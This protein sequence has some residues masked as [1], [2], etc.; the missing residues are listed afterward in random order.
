MLPMCQ[1][2][3]CC[4][5]T[6]PPVAVCHQCATN[7]CLVLSHHHAMGQ[8]CYQCDHNLICAIAPHPMLRYA[9]SN[10]ALSIGYQT[11]IIC[12][13]CYDPA[14]ALT[15]LRPPPFISNALPMNLL[16]IHATDMLPH[17]TPYLPI[18]NYPCHKVPPMRSQLASQY[19]VIVLGPPP[20]AINTLWAPCRM[21]SMHYPY[22]FSM[23]SP[24][25][26]RT[27]HPTICT[28]RYGP[29]VLCY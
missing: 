8:I 14:T 12:D 9:P 7:A 27:L 11:I 28:L 26:Q 2:I 25:Y 10:H 16:L 18:C 13:S 19:A 29:H 4:P 15:T 3:Q 20:Y 23:L 22:A 5:S 17:C 1:V 21:Q 6:P 24:C